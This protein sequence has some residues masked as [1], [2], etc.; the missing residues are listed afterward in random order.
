LENKP[1][2]FNLIPI[3]LD[4]NL[5]P[6]NKRNIVEKIE[7]WYREEGKREKTRGN[8]NGTSRGRDIL[9]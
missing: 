9:Y 7:S 4:W 6:E 2:A 3:M 8:G 5:Q 1:F